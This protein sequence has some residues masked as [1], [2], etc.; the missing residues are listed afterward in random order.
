M[1]VFMGVELSRL[2]RGGFTT[3]LM[4]LKLQGPSLEQTPSKALRGV[5]AVCSP[6]HTFCKICK[7]YE[8]SRLSVITVFQAVR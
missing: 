6:C 8:F 1:W 3:L 7:D 5:L 4:K 2:A